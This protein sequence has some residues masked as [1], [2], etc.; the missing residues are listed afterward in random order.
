MV[1]A[2]KTDRTLAVQGE[3]RV[4]VKAD[5]AW[6]RLGVLTEAKLAADAARDNAEVAQKVA[7]MVQK[8]GIPADRMRTAS[9]NL[10]P[11]VDYSGGG[12]GVVVGYRAENTIVVE[13]AVDLAG[14]VFDTGVSAGATQSSDLSFGIRDEAPHRRKALE[15][16]VQA[17]HGDAEAVAKAMGATLGQAHSVEIEPGGGP[18]VLRRG[19]ATA[20]SAET[21]IL[22]GDLTVSARLRVVY[23]VR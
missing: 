23:Q 12:A 5:V 10:Y 21:P 6:V 20:K 11:V 9:L 17:A 15:A 3:G 18:T 13:T 7:G 16:A 22:P 4:E 2:D 8:L 14:K 19:A 1:E